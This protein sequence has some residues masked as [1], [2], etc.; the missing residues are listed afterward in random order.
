M[1]ALK[2]AGSIVGVWLGFKLSKI[3]IEWLKEGLNG[4]RPKNFRDGF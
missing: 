3:A 1:I 2:I 4:L